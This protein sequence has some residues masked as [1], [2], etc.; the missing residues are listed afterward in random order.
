MSSNRSNAP[1]K[2]DA[3][4]R[5]KAFINTTNTPT[6][7]TNFIDLTLLLAGKSFHSFT[8]YYCRHIAADILALLSYT[9]G[10]YHHSNYW[11]IITLLLSF[12]SVLA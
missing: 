5:Y 12:P 9:E 11:G 2:I 4:R 8:L 7:T 6:H 1:A 10:P 3:D